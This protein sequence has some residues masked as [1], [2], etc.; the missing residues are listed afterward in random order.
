MN[1]LIKRK[2]NKLERGLELKNN[3][4]KNTDM[5][6]LTNQEKVSKIT[7]NINKINPKEEIRRLLKIINLLKKKKK[8]PKNK[9]SIIKD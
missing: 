7:Y 3:L 5:I 4:R 2:S 1:N 9:V 6:K 8:F